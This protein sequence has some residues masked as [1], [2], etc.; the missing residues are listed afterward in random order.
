M[1]KIDIGQI[2]TIQMDILT[3]V[4]DFCVK[5]NI[6]YSLCGGS[7]IGAIRHKGFIPW[8]DDIDIF[9]LRDDYEQLLMKFEDFSCRYKILS[10]KDPSYSLPFAKVEDT[11]TILKE[12]TNLKHLIGVNIDIFPIDNLVD[13]KKKSIKILHN[14]GR[15]RNI[16]RAKLLRPNSNNSW[17][18]KCVILLSSLFLSPFTLKWLSSKLNEK[19]K[20]AGVPNSNYVSTLVWGYG[21]REMVE[22]RLFNDYK[23]VGFEDRHY[24]IMSGYDQYLHQVYGNYMQLPPKEKRQSPHAICSVYWK[25]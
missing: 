14:I 18:K 21:E 13:D 20:V 4:H 6:H 23:L 2:K 16:T 19:A 24:F 25:D 8:D 5:N 10:L 3:F 12:D 17:M 15:L 9:M 11:R 1:R 7:A 22:R